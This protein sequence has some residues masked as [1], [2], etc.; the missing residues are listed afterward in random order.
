MCANGN[1]LN[2]PCG[3]IPCHWTS[4]ESGGEESIRSVERSHAFTRCGVLMRSLD[5]HVARVVCY[6]FYNANAQGH[7]WCC[8][9]SSTVHGARLQ[10]L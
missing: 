9:L 1:G 2:G 8:G 7:Q 3:I 5:G 10:A 4:T 6:H